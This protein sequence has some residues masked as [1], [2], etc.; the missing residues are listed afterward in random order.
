M[1]TGGKDRGEE[2]TEERTEERRGKK[3]Q[4]NREQ[5]TTTTG[6]DDTLD[7]L[8]QYDNQHQ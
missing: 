6:Y 4:K 5:R 7:E 1:R 8:P 2:R 3:K